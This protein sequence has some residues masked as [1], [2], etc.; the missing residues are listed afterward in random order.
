M[1]SKLHGQRKH[2]LTVLDAKA[3]SPLPEG[4]LF[5]LVDVTLLEE[6]GGAVLHGNEGDPERG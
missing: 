5:V 3:V 4:H 2:F 6:Q 1:A